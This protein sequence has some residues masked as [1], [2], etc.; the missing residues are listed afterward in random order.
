M[1]I[2]VLIK[3]CMKLIGTIYNSQSKQDIHIQ[4]IYGLERRFD[5]SAFGFHRSQLL[6]LTH[7]LAMRMKQLLCWIVCRVRGWTPSDM[8]VEYLWS[9]ELNLVIPYTQSAT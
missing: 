2:F 4:W 9:C 7:M 1:E 6:A 3:V 5:Q 8:A